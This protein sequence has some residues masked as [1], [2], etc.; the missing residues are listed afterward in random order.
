MIHGDSYEAHMKHVDLDENSFVEVHLFELEAY[1]SVYL[2][3]ITIPSKFRIDHFTFLTWFCISILVTINKKV[4]LNR[5]YLDR[6]FV[7]EYPSSRPDPQ[8]HI[9]NLQPSIRVIEFAQRHET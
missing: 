8:H 7:V 9:I 3:L 6:L 2:S 1:L 4:W 5:I